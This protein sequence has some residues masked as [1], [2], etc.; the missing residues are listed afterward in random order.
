MFYL[1]SADNFI[2][3][4]SSG[5]F[6]KIILTNC[7]THLAKKNIFQTRSF[8]SDELLIYSVLSNA[9]KIHSRLPA[10]MG[11]LACMSRDFGIFM[12]KHLAE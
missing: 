7:D 3:D 10:A 12:L 2:F 8:I 9:A 5:V 1:H 6:A 4:F 11:I